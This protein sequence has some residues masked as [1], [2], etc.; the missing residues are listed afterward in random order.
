MRLCGDRFSLVRGGRHEQDDIDSASEIFRESVLGSSRSR[1]G[2]I[3]RDSDKKEQSENESLCFALLGIDEPTMEHVSRSLYRAV[4]RFARHSNGVPF[5]LSAIEARAAVPLLERGREEGKGGESRTDDGKNLDL[6]LRRLDSALEAH[7]S[8]F[9]SSS[10]WDSSSLVRKVARIAA[11]AGREIA[12]GQSPPEKEKEEALDA[13]FRALQSLNGEHWHSVAAAR[14]SRAE[15]SRRDPFGSVQR[16]KYKIGDVFVHRQYGYRAVITG[17]DRSCAKGPEWARAV[18]AS[19][20][21]QPFYSCLPDSGDCVS[22]FGA[23]RSSKY[24]AEENVDKDVAKLPAGGSRVTHPLLRSFFEGWREEGGEGEGGEGGG[25]TGGGRGGGRGRYIGNA[26]LRYE[27]PDDFDEE[28]SG[29]VVGSS[30]SASAVEDDSNLLLSDG[31]REERRRRGGG[32]GGRR[33]VEGEEK[34]APAAAPP[35]SASAEPAAAAAA[36]E[37][38]ER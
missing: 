5:S 38:V 31:E 8:S 7:A 11:E 3:Q 20:A 18:G 35:A 21:R 26:R 22:L 27:F 17:W 37:G 1:R 10:S 14:A 30:C 19:T 15:H 4:L 6:L 33:R 32:R 2:E 36:A 28:S 13:A 16:P 24:V 9:S 12:G 23:A 29:D 34:P 25:G